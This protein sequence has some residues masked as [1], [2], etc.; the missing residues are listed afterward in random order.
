M[1]W[2]GPCN[3]FPMVAIGIVKAS[4]GIRGLQSHNNM[5]Y[6]SFWTYYKHDVTRTYFTNVLQLTTRI[7]FITK[8]KGTNHTGISSAT[9]SVTFTITAHNLPALC[10]RNLIFVRTRGVVSSPDSVGRPIF[11][12]LPKQ[13]Q[14]IFFCDRLAVGE[15]TIPNALECSLSISRLST[16]QRSIDQNG[17]IPPGDGGPVHRTIWEQAKFSRFV[18]GG[19]I[20][21]P[22]SF[23]HGGDLLSDSYE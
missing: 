13:L 4:F 16:I 15:V 6:F 17:D 22:S 14:H 11:F 8:K 1:L 18:T 10:T 12:N 23:S 9:V 19:G 21:L 3:G 20:C 7:G 5:G 2:A